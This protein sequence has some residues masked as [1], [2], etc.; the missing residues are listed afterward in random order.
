MDRARMPQLAPGT[1]HPDWEAVYGTS[2]PEKLPW[3]LPA[4]DPDLRSALEAT[5]MR[6]LKI[7]EVGCG[8]G[9]QAWFM[10]QLGHDVT[11]TDISPAAIER[12]R[13]LH[14]GPRFLVDDITRT[15]LGDT[16]DLIVDRGC[17]HVLDPEAH[18]A[19]LQSLASLVRPGGLVFVKVF[20]QENRKTSFGPQRFSQLGLVR[21]FTGS[22][23]LV[24]VQR[25]VY[26]GSTPHSPRAWFAVARRRLGDD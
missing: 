24:R 20:S 12:A 2:E 19:Y 6:R 1:R 9:N 26:Q 14:P 16:F 17:L 8:L 11:A 5:G 13:S 23:S 7:L 4:F 21:L 15:E 18:G 3:H 22:F 25:T 10:A